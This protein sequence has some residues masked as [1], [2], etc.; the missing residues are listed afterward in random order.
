M[1]YNEITTKKQ[2]SRLKYQLMQVQKEK[3]N[4]NKNK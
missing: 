4:I 2:V 3:E 1:G